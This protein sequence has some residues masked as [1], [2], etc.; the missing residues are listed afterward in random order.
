LILNE[1]KFAII[2]PIMVDIESAT[3]L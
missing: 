3:F 1:D 2:L